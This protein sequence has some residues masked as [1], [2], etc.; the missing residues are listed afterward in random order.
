M[1]IQLF[2]AVSPRKSIQSDPFQNNLL[3][4]RSHPFH[5]PA[6]YGTQLDVALDVSLDPA[7]SALEKLLDRRRIA[8]R[9]Q[10]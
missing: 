7:L 8:L 3:R 10:L 1:E 9:C 5:R 4:Q 2:S 6:L